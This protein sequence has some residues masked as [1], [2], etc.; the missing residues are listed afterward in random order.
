MGGQAAAGRW[1]RGELNV[2]V[3]Q[4]EQVGVIASPIRH[5]TIHTW[6]QVVVV[7]FSIALCT[8]GY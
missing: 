8:L 2:V 3:R 6:Y 1:S 5:N 4:G 7:L